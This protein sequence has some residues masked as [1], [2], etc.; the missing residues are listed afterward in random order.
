[1][2]KQ[3]SVG[4]IL[5]LLLGSSVALGATLSGIS[6]NSFLAS[7]EEN[8]TFINENTGRHLL[9][10]GIT[11]RDSGEGDGRTV[12]EITGEVLSLTVRTD[13][14]GGIVEMCQ[15]V[16]TAPAGMEIGNAAYNDFTTSGYHSYALLM[17]MDVAST[18][19]ERYA[20]VQKVE[21]GLKQSEGSFTTQIGLYAL[22]CTN[23]SGTVTLSF[24]NSAVVAPESTAESIESETPAPDENTDEGAGMG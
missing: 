6:Y 10:L 12:Y 24:E 14:T 22:V 3:L 19:A 13:P 4:L 11:K 15:M 8:I 2:K 9:P 5:L 21:E 18:P 7:Y 16:L 20:L 23:T 1:M 17:A